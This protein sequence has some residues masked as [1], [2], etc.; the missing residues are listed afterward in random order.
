[1][2]KFAWMLIELHR[3]F[4]MLGGNVGDTICV[5]QS[6][7]K[8]LQEMGVRI[9]AVS[10]VFRTEPWGYSNQRSF[11][12]Q[13]AFIE[14]KLSAVELMRLLQYIEQFH[15][16]ATMFANGPRTLDLDL[17]FFDS[18]IMESDSLTIPHPRAH[19]RR[20]NLEPLSEIASEFV[21]PKLNKM[22]KVLLEECQDELNVNKISC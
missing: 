22:I 14:T 8:M 2:D 9:L 12:N 13:A 15:G 3:S 11:L 18:M 16:K 7:V 5:F 10:S 17:V 1:M 6:A 20:F 21:H 19:L 4:I